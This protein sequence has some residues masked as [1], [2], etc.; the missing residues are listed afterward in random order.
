MH[1]PR[2]CRGRTAVRFP[3]NS[4]HICCVELAL[5]RQLRILLGSK[6][7]LRRRFPPFINPTTLPRWWA[8][9]R[10]K[11]VSVAAIARVKWLCACERYWPGRGLVY[12]CVPLAS[13]LHYFQ[14][15]RIKFNLSFINYCI[16]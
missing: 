11:Q 6:R 8:P 10:A 13:S 14:C 1:L 4:S 2:A 15:N 12:I 3:A 9:I 16:S 5:G 7:F